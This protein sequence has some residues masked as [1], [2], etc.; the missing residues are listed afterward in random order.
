[1][2]TTSS[3]PA[4][5]QR[6]Q[7]TDVAAACDLL[8]QAQTKVDEGSWTKVRFENLEQVIGINCNPHGVLFDRELQQHTSLIGAV[9]YDWVHNMLQDGVFTTEAWL[10]L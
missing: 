4:V 2:E 10:Y 3:D 7:D 6:W 1:V 5:F 8:V 9:T